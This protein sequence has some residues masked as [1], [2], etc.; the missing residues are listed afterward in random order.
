MKISHRVNR[1]RPEYW[2]SSQSITSLLK[3]TCETRGTTLLSYCVSKAANFQRYERW[4]KQHLLIILSFVVCA[5]E[6]RFRSSY[7]YPT[8][9]ALKRVISR[10]FVMTFA[11]VLLEH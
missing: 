9:R 4:I 10:C 5:F 7:Q 6:I 2:G 3:S 8:I 11:F 1:S